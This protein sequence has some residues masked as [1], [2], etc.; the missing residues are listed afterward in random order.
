M[1]REELEDL[2]NQH[3]GRLNILHILEDNSAEITL[4]RGRVDGDK[5]AALFAAWIDAASVDMAYICGPEPMMRGV[6]D[7][8]T[9]QGLGKDQI[10]FELF[11]PTQP[12]RL[13]VRAVSAEAAR[14]GTP[15]RLT[16]NATPHTLTV[17]ARHQPA[18]RSV[19][20]QPST[21]PMRVRQGSVQRVRRKLL[22][23]KVEMIANHALE[24]DEVTA[25][26]IL[27]CQSHPVS[28]DEVV[29]DYDAA[30]H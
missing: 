12:G 17:P 2:K 26:Y 14:D 18:G 10:R 1:F 5:C 9:A 25:G 15:A 4:F 19:K 28:E 30:G 21:H 7:A 23:G 22:H 16:L 6:S 8:L 13:P 24:D 27:T 3:M 29:W 11:A 20:G